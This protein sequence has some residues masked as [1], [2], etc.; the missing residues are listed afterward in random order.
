MKYEWINGF[1]VIVSETQLI[2]TLSLPSFKSFL[3]SMGHPPNPLPFWIF[4]SLSLSL[5]LQFHLQPLLFSSEYTFQVSSTVEK[6][7]YVFIFLIFSVSSLSSI[8]ERMTGFDSKFFD[9]FFI[10]CYRVI[11]GFSWFWFV[12]EFYGFL[13]GDF[14]FI[15][16]VV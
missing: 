16:S 4:S 1:R 3:S 14:N 2:R 11:L 7:R 10:G 8:D 5:H 15:R 12:C 9:D 6:S 13:Y